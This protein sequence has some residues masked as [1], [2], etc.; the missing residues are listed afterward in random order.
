VGR[1]IKK[2]FH[3]LHTS[4]QFIHLE[5]PTYNKAFFYFYEREFRNDEAALKEATK[6]I[7]WAYKRR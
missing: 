6:I 7:K 3:Y 1:T 4:G 5:I 2:S